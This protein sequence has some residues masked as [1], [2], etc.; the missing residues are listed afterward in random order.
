MA[1]K[2]DPKKNAPITINDLSIQDFENLVKK[3]SEDNKNTFY[4]LNQQLNS[5][6]NKSLQEAE[7]TK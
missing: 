3:V 7:Y 5:N 2:K 4:A 6:L 1:P